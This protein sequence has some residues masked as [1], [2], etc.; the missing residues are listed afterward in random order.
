[1]LHGQLPDDAD[2]LDISVV[3]NDDPPSEDKSIL[4]F[5]TPV[6]DQVILWD[7]PAHQLSPPLGDDI[8]MLADDPD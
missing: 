6:E 3:G 2:V 8:V 4:T 1:M 5:V 7:D